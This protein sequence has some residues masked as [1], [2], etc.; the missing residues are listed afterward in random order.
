MKRGMLIVFVVAAFMFAG[1]ASAACDL[2]TQLLSQDPYPAVP[3]DYVKLVFQVTGLQSLDCKD[4]SFELVPN[5]PISF[6]PGTSSTVVVKGG[7]YTGIDYS[8]NLVVPFKVR[9]DPEAVDGNNPITVKYTSSTLSNSS[10]TKQFNLMVNN[11]RTD[12]DVFVKDY[13]FTTNTMTLE[14]LN[15]GK[16]DVNALAIKIPPQENFT[17][18]GPNVN[19]VGSLDSNDYTTADFEITPGTGK[20]D[21]TIYYNDAVGIRRSVNKTV[22]FD[23]AQFEG[24]KTTASSGSA[25][26]YII[27]AIVIVAVVGYIFYRRYKKNKK[28]K[29][30]RE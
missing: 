11:T 17:V 2:N 18:K 6:D 29:L 12:F 21:M 14:I 19:V 25:T 4:V 1:L 9:V 15:I 23:P 24:Q 22:S 3:G 13:D 7:T 5:Y 30:L 8:P 26:G 28:K 16:N 27:L 20:L 10:L